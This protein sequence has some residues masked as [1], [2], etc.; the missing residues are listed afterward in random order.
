MPGEE[1]GLVSTFAIESG[2]MTHQGCFCSHCA[3]I[4]L[5]EDASYIA[6]GQSFR[7]QLCAL[8]S[9]KLGCGSQ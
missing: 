8:M 2:V 3:K 1:A 6:Q 4:A 9:R 7:P 5:S